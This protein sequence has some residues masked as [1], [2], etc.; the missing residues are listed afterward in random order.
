MQ[1]YTRRY[2][3]KIFKIVLKVTIYFVLIMFIVSDS[4]T[5]FLNPS[6]VPKSILKLI[7]LVGMSVVCFIPIKY[8]INRI[9]LRQISKISQDGIV[10]TTIVEPHNDTIVSVLREVR[11]INHQLG[12]VQSK[13]DNVSNR[14]QNLEGSLPYVRPVT[15]GV[16]RIM[17]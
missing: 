16:N 6:V 14:I 1:K 5:V 11:Y 3:S 9:H 17:L 15:G 7:T 12:V 2:N 13:L 8:V 4:L 10:T